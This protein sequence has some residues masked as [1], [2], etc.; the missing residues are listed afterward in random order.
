MNATL[1]TLA[2]LGCV[3]MGLAPEAQA[4]QVPS[5]GRLAGV[6]G[7]GRSPDP[8]ARASLDSVI[9]AEARLVVSAGRVD[10]Y[11]DQVAVDPELAALADRAVAEMERIAGR[12][13]D[14]ETLGARITLVVSSRVTVSHVWRGYEHP[15]DP[16]PILFLNPRV[17]RLSLDGRN[18]TYA[19]ELAHL[20]TWRFHSHSLREGVADYLALAVHP[21]AGVG[22]NPD[23]YGADA[24]SRP[25]EIIAVLGTTAPAPATVSSDERLRRDYY[26]ASYLV[27]RCLIARGGI[28]R[29]WEVY[30][31]PDPA[32]AMQR[33]YA[34]SRE[35]LVSQ[36]LSGQDCG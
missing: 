23:G 19:H 16:R 30:D 27:A 32:A 31:A 24:P 3:A 28:A 7:A 25:P 36:A 18:A 5:D 17:A 4:Q 14:V 1:T 33:V 35:T 34:A 20:L 11:A 13:W 26:H 22:P 21:G 10:L 8:G 9:V 29:F 15:A 6:R 12:R 2:L